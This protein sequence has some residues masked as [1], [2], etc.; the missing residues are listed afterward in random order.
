MYPSLDKVLLVNSSALISEHKSSIMI[1]TIPGYFSYCKLLRLVISMW[2]YHRGAERVENRK[3]ENHGN[4]LSQK[5]G[6]VAVCPRS[7]SA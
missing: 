7:L 5:R 2:N 1:R 6:S 4:V 3:E